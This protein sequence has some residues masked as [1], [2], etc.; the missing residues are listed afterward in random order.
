MAW[1]KKMMMAQ[2]T[3]L[4]PTITSK[5]IAGWTFSSLLFIVF[6]GIFH[7]PFENNSE[8]AILVFVLI[9][10]VI[11][12]II[13]EAALTIALRFAAI[14]ESSN[15]HHRRPDERHNDEKGAERIGSD[16]IADFME[17]CLCPFLWNQSDASIPR[18]PRKPGQSLEQIERQ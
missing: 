18:H 6:R 4:P 5:L 3:R 17:H 11:I 12:V 9:F 10:I 14:D 7:S 16:E 8:L 15:H 2:R 1:P 13:R